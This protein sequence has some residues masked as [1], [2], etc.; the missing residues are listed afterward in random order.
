VWAMPPSAAMSA[1]S[2]TSMMHAAPLVADAV[3]GTALGSSTEKR[4]A[5]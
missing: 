2:G 4:T 1:A 3:H 5:A